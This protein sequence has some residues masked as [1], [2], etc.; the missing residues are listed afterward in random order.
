M[1]NLYLNFHVVTLNRKSRKE[2]LFVLSDIEQKDAFDVLKKIFAENKGVLLDSKGRLTDYEIDENKRSIFGYVEAGEQGF[3]SSFVD[4]GSQKLVYNRKK[5]DLELIPFYFLISAPKDSK[6]C[7]IAVQTLGLS[8]PYDVISHLV[9]KAFNSFDATCKF[10]AVC[11][12]GKLIEQTLKNNGQI[13]K[14]EAFKAQ[15]PRDK[16]GDYVSKTFV[17]REFSGFSQRIISEIINDSSKSSL[18]TLFAIGEI[19]NYK[20]HIKDRKGRKRCLNISSTQATNYDI[21]DIKLNDK[22]HPEFEEMVK[23]SNEYLEN[24]SELFQ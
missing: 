11:E 6:Y 17:R 2:D 21:S 7:F 5:Q 12:N 1:P 15:Q 20:L 9:K 19:D 4:L 24:I 18:S 13:L 10:K 14:I 16:A 23:I 3:T 8:S 22:G